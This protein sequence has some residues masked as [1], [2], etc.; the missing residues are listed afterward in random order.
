MYVYV[1]VYIYIYILVACVFIHIIYIYIYIVDILKQG[2]IYDS[3]YYKLW[4]NKYL[5]NTLLSNLQRL[6]HQ[7][8]RIIKD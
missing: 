7:I 4:L 2:T 3:L 6:Y 1:Y 8:G 5:R